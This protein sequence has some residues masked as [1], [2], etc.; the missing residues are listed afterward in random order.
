MKFWKKI[1][2]FVLT[3][4]LIIPLMFTFTACGGSG[5]G[6]G[7]NSGSGGTTPVTP[8]NPDPP[9]LTDPVL[10]SASNSFAG[11]KA[12]YARTGYTSVSGSATTMEKLLDTQIDVFGSRY[13]I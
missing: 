11:A 6:G 7:G 4:C 5:G 9:A 2:H 13:I 8:V 10:Q 12:I 3:I 1:M